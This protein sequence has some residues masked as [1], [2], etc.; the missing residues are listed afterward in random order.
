[1]CVCVSVCLSMCVLLRVCG[2]RLVVVTSWLKRGGDSVLR[3]LWWCHSLGC[4]FSVVYKVQQIQLNLFPVTRVSSFRF[5][6]L[7]SWKY[8]SSSDDSTAFTSDR[9][10]SENSVFST[11]Q[12]LCVCVCVCVWAAARR[13]GVE[14]HRT[15]VLRTLQRFIYDAVTAIKTNIYDNRWCDSPTGL[16]LRLNLPSNLQWPTGTNANINLLYICYWN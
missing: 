2:K 14:S 8:T 15:I 12:R 9:S 10:R 5:I 6:K 3:S 16:S 11:K 1:M 13:F 7:N 4:V